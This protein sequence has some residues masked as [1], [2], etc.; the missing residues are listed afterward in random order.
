MLNVFTL[1]AALVLARMLPP[2]LAALKIPVAR[3]A[4]LVR[5][6]QVLEP[7]PPGGKLP[8]QQG[9]LAVMQRYL[10]IPA[11]GG[12][13]GVAV[14]DAAT[15]KLLYTSQPGTLVTPAST[16]KVVTSVASLAV[17]GANAR[18]TTRAVASG[19]NVILVGGGDPT[20]AVNSYP[21]GDYP[22]PATLARLASVTAE[23][24]KAHGQHVIRLGYDTSMYT[25]APMAPAWSQSDID[26][27]NVTPISALEV[28]QGRLTTSGS[29]Q[30]FDDPVNFRPRTMNPAG[31]A[32]KAFVTLLTADGITIHGDPSP[33][34]APAGAR[35]LASVSSPPLSAMV[36]QMLLE[37]NNVIAENLAR[38]LALATGRPASFAGSAAAVM[39]EL[40]R[41]GIGTPISLV[42]GSG[43][44]PKDRIAPV[45][46]V[47]VVRLAASAGHGGLRAAVTGMPVAGFSGTLSA[48]G[49]VFGGMGGA[50][51]GV[52]R[53]KTGNLETV[54]TLAGLVEDRDGRLL[55]FAIMTDQ[56]PSPAALGKAAGAID[57][58]AAGL[59]ACGCG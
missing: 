45:T 28:D 46:L 42:D 36:S 57:A 59:A 54:A 44:S 26:T 13:P 50:A 31:M 23:A 20:L 30:D 27:G 53:A 10:E 1:A 2:R 5:A 56:I 24:L 15:G 49:S 40:R 32:V 14:A 16:T 21:A 12:K 11:V 48:G 51:R 58:A 17:L 25:G 19:N 39:A 38:H 47:Q 41:L 22:Q 43:L 4:P 29:P 6:G 9:L 55:A 52:L 3:N 37:S 33:E 8:T 7:D 35:R 18:F 34:Q